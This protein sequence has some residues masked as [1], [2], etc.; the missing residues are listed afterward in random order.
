M[1][2]RISKYVVYI[3][4]EFNDRDNMDVNDALVSVPGYVDHEWLDWTDA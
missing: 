4:E 2:K 3:E 1:T